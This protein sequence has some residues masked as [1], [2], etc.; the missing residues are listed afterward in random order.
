MLILLLLPLNILLA[1][2][3]ID[4]L[5]KESFEL[6]LVIAVVCLLHVLL[7]LKVLNIMESH[8]VPHTHVLG[9]PAKMVV[10][11]L[12]SKNYSFALTR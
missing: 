11:I 4:L 12:S 3:F 5:V 7:F 1:F 8:S 9:S 10:S 2:D 6:L